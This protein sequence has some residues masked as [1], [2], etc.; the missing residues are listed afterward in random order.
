MH[1]VIQ[2]KM[3]KLLSRIIIIVL[4]SM[5]TFESYGSSSESEED[6]DSNRF[7]SASSV[8]SAMEDSHMIIGLVE[9]K[10]ICKQRST[11]NRVYNQIF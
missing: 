1:N 9:S 8:F 10:L 2:A 6:S 4:V 5:T 3:M 11:V 7:R